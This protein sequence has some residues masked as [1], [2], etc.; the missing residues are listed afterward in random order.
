MDSDKCDDSTEMAFNNPVL[1]Q[2]HSLRANAG[3]KH[4]FHANN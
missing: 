4:C 3:N 1:K 2:R